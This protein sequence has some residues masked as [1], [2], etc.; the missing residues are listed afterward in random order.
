MP[1]NYG[2][3]VSMRG[4]RWIYNVETDIFIFDTSVARSNSDQ[5]IGFRA[6]SELW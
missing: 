4:G 1:P 6:S 3:H 2:E 5:G